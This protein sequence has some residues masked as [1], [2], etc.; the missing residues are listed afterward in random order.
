MNIQAKNADIDSQIEAALDG[1]SN[2]PMTIAT[3]IVNVRDAITAIDRDIAS[4][5]ADRR[6]LDERLA[7][8]KARMIGAMA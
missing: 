5:K 4:R 3:Q 6:E 1:L 2:D 8:L 7:G